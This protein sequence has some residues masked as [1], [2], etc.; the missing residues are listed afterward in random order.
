MPADSIRKVGNDLEAAVAA[1]PRDLGPGD[2]ILVKGRGSQALGRI[3]LM[4]SG[5]RVR[6][7][8]V[9]CPM[10]EWVS[11]DHCGMLER[12]WVRPGIP[13]TGEVAKFAAEDES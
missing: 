8:V 7:R 6:C 4:L 10:F 3:A 1:L 12:G 13:V 11:C 2:V 5:R 9:T